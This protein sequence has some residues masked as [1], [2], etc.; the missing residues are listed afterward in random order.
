MGS[1]S[2]F[3]PDADD[4]GLAAFAV[5]PASGRALLVALFE[6]GLPVW[7]FRDGGGDDGY[8]VTSI[9]SVGS[10]G[11][12]I[13]VEVGPDPRWARILFREDRRESVIGV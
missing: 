8:V 5:D 3:V 4:A 10:V 1:R 2:R 6:R 13:E 11:V 12:E 9:V 7:L